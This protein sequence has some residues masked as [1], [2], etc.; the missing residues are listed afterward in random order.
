MGPTLSVITF[1]PHSHGHFS[2]SRKA[3]L[4]GPKRIVN[5]QSFGNAFVNVTEVT[6]F[7]ASGQILWSRI[8]GR[9]AKF[10]YLGD[11]TLNISM[12]RG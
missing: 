1:S 3:P 6:R 9:Q 7:R 5:E 4:D 8:A 12:R 10:A 2:V 11:E